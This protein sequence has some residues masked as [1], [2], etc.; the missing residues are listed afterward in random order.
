MKEV[1]ALTASLN[2]VKHE[3]CEYSGRSDDELISLIAKYRDQEA[4]NT[5]YKR[6]WHS[7][8][9]FLK[10]NQYESS[11]VDK[12]YND[13]MLSVWNNAETFNDKSDA[14]TWLFNIAYQCRHE[15]ALSL[16]HI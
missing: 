13:I 6:Y 3:R 11:V 8:A 12:L 2:E 16:I 10:R 7:I 9:C 1:G 5:L 14:S 4:L 15:Y